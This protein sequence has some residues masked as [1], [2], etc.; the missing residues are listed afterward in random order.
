MKKIITYWTF[1]LLHIGHIN[2]LKRAKELW[3]YL[4]VWLSTDEF[5]VIKHKSSIL[6]FND[7]KV[8]LESIKYVDEVIEESNREQ[9][10]NDIK[11]HNIDIFVMWGDWEWK[12]DFLKD[13]C[14]VRYFPRT[15]EISTNI[16]KNSL[17][18]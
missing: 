6:S 16:I 14:E 15:P 12:F 13:L 7:R 4:I 5:N 8:I 3:D 2:I 9:K 1:D 11:E 18:N 10:I 17:N